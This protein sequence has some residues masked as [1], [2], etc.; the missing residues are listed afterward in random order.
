MAVIAYNNNSTFLNKMIT[1][2]RQTLQKTVNVLKILF[3]VKL[4]APFDAVSALFLHGAADSTGIHSLVTKLLAQQQNES[5]QKTTKYYSYVSL[6]C[7]YS[8]S[9]SNCLWSLWSQ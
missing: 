7:C 3:I 6:A 1:V 4:F 5:S 8:S 9:V 2:I